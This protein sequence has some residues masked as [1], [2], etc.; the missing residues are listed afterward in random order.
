MVKWKVKAIQ[1]GTINSNMSGVLHYIGESR[2]VVLPIWIVAATDGKNKVLIDTGIDDL[3]SVVAGPEPNCRQEKEEETLTALKNMMGWEPE[4][5]NFIINT[6]L[7]FDHCGCNKYFKNA[8]ICVQKK[9]WE[10]AHHP[11]S[12]TA[13][14]YYRPFFDKNAVPYFQW[15]FV[16]GETEL[17]P[18]LAVIPTPGHTE[19]HQSVLVNTEEGVLCVAGDI[20]TIADN[21]NRNIEANIVVDAAKVYESFVRIRDRARLILPGH[22]FSVKNGAESGFPLI[23]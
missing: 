1:V 19:G 16:E 7:H 23:D 20:V 9:E 4:E 3:A 2:P 17:M 15:Q 13:F 18:G 12:S 6:H 21:I 10:S 8:R 14:L 5:V 11:I 22:E